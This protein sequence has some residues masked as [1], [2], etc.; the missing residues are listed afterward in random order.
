MK[1]LQ[2]YYNQL[3]LFFNARNLR[4]RILIAGLMAALIFNSWLY[5]LHDPLVFAHDKYSQQLAGLT[6]QIKATEVQY[7]ILV[8]TRQ[9]DPNR[10]VRQRLVLAQQH[11]DK[12]DEQLHLKMDGLIKPTEMAKVLEQVLTQQTS[13]R[14]VRIQ[15]LAAKPLIIPTEI[16]DDENNLATG[17][18]AANTDFTNTA[19]GVYKHGIEMEFNG[20]YLETLGYLKQLQQLPW[21]FYWDDVLF[22]VVSYPKSRIIIRVHTLSLKEGWIGV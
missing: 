20:S 4:E 13:L 18:T 3:N 19:I 22:D 6:Q 16:P 2:Q 15:S 17:T 21:N 7:S 11:I 5:L 12:L 8:K 10:K 1:L 9:V 14:F